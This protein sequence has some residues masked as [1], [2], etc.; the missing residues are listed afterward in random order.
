M[1]DHKYFCL[2]FVYRSNFCF[3]TRMAKSK[4]IIF[5]QICI[6]LDSN[7]LTLE[8][9]RNLLKNEWPQLQQ[10]RLGNYFYILG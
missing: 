10:L 7:K 5:M 2:R 9:V 6:K 1:R 4:H 8:G 3:P